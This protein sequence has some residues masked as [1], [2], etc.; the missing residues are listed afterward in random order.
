MTSGAGRP[1]PGA[2]G[3]RQARREQHARAPRRPRRRA[4]TIASDDALGRAGPHARRPGSRR[5]GRSRGPCRGRRTAGAPTVAAPWPPSGASRRVTSESG[6][7][8]RPIPRPAIAQVGIPTRST[9]TSGMRM[10]AK[11]AIADRRARRSPRRRTGGHPSDRTGAPGSTTRPVHVQGRGGEHDAG[12][13]RRQAAPV[14]EGERDVGVRREE[15]RGGD[16]AQEDRG[17]QAAGG[18]ERAGRR[19]ATEGRHDEDEAA[20]DEDGGRGRRIGG[21]PADDERRADGED[22]RERDPPPGR[23]AIAAPAHPERADGRAGTAM[24]LRRVIAPARTTSGS[25]PRKTMRQPSVWVIAA[26]QRRADDARQDP[27]RRERREHLAAAAAPAATGR[28]PRRPSAGSRRPRGP[29]GTGRRRAP[30]STGR[31][32]R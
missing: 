5:R 22:E 18:A 31:G 20:D 30:P 21:Q 15:R 26:G 25:R 16:A 32:R 19:Q 23:V 4:N 3:A 12:R 2:R 28:S 7:Y 1:H 17:R 13:R 14:L 8:S 9:G 11:V 29:G 10:S 24:R 6:A 27:G